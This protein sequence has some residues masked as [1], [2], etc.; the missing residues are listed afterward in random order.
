MTYL[1]LKTDLTVEELVIDKEISL[2]LL[3]EI[4]GGY[5]EAFRISPMANMAAMINEEGLLKNLPRNPYLGKIHGNIVLGNQDG[6]EFIGLTIVQRALIINNVKKVI[7]EITN[8]PVE[9]SKLIG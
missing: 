2:E 8:T 1:V 3:Q 9:Y 4:V 7:K 5:I 6:D